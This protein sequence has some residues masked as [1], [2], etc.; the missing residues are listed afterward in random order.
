MRPFMSG[1]LESIVT[2]S[3]Q[4]MHISM[5][6]RDTLIHFTTFRN[7]GLVPFI[8]W[9]QTS[10]LRQGMHS[11]IRIVA[12]VTTDMWLHVQRDGQHTCSSNCRSWYQ[13]AWSV[14][15]SVQFQ[16]WLTSPKPIVC[17]LYCLCCLIHWLYPQSKSAFIP[18]SQD[19]LWRLVW[20]GFNTNLHLQGQSYVFCIVSVV[21]FTN[22]IPSQK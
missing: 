21:Q 16:H 6:I 12:I 22:S 1:V 4:Q 14:T 5:C 20:F 18:S 7:I 11:I 10:I 13:P 19:F 3:F 17:L 2:Q 9:C 8:P 15:H